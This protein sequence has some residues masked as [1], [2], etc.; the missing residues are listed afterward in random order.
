MTPTQSL[1]SVLPCPGLSAANASYTA[2]F[3]LHL[4]TAAAGTGLTPA[5]FAARPGATLL[6]QGS[7][8]NA[9]NAELY[10]TAAA[11]TAAVAVVAVTAGSLT[12]SIARAVGAA[13]DVVVTMSLTVTLLGATASERNDASAAVR[14]LLYSRG[15]GP[16]LAE[17]FLA[18]GDL[19]A[20]FGLPAQ[21]NVTLAQ[22]SVAFQCP[23]VANVRGRG[24]GAPLPAHC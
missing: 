13:T 10:G 16:R 23:V 6:L 7:V 21:P 8:V 5:A 14:A 11:E 20:A 22:D 19:R 4:L 3:D 12:T 1:P 9:V 17:Q 18:T 24:R 2:T 15:A